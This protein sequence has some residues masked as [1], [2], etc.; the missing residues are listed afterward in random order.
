MLKRERAVRNGTQYV[1]PLTLQTAEE[2]HA[3]L[4]REAEQIRRAQEQERREIR[5]R[6]NPERARVRRQRERDSHRGARLAQDAES[7]RIRR[8]MENDEQRNMRLEDNAERARARRETES[9]VQRERRLAEDAERVQVR[10]QQENDEQR[11]MSLAAF[12]DCCNHGNI[13]IRHFVNYP[14]ELCQ[15]LT[16]QNPEAREFREHIRSYNSAFAFV[17]RG[18]K[19][20]TTPGHGPYCFRIHHGQIYQRI[21]PARPEISQPH[22]FGQLYILDTSMAAEERMGNPAN[23]N[24]IPRLIRSLSTLLHQVNAFAQ[25]YK[26]LNEVA[27][28]EDLHAAG[29][30]R[31]SL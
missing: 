20:D 6:Q 26:M 9:G 28:E 12:N 5:Q 23:T 30:E 25:A 15:L 3:R 31:R 18:A 27:L 17:S 2:R 29:E 19:L 1:V 10:R 16:C 7:A 4:Q 13:C 22:R 24:C 8:Q 14:E 11:E 21:G